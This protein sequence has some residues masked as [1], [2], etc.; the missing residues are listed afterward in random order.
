MKPEVLQ[1]GQVIIGPL[2]H[3]TIQNWHFNAEGFYGASDGYSIRELQEIEWAYN[4]AVKDVNEILNG[5]GD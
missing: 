4:N 2:G 1:V 3:I 5:A